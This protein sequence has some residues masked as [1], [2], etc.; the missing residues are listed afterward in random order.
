MFWF[1]VVL[2]ALGG[3]LLG[4]TNPWQFFEA[5][6]GGFFDWTEVFW[7][8]QWGGFWLVAGSLLVFGGL[9]WR[10]PSTFAAHWKLVPAGVAA[11]LFVGFFFCSMPEKSNQP[12]WKNGWLGGRIYWRTKI[13]MRGDDGDEP[14]IPR[15]MAGRWE[16]PGG[17][18]FSIAPDSLRM[19]TPT[20]NTEWNA[21]TCPW[22]FRMDYDFTYRPALEQ[23][24]MTP[25][26]AF[27]KLNSARPGFVT[28]LPDRRFPRL[29]CSCDSKSTMW[30]LVDIDRLLAFP[31]D[32]ERPVI[33]RRR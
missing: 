4:F 9:A 31:D 6:S 8:F 30:V 24:A 10:A 16:A 20:A 1:G 15:R 14:G 3:L 2:L 17:L 13:W 11:V 12:D 18:E 23:Q 26:L 33:A 25:G 22:R 7:Y 32:D 28:G 29:Y 27:E 21:R 5:I 19:K